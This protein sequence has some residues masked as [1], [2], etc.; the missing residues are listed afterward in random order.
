MKKEELKDIT[1]VKNVNILEQLLSSVN[2][3][4]VSCQLKLKC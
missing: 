2:Y 1:Y 3:A 4:V